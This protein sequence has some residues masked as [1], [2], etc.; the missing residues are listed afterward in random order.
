MSLDNGRVKLITQATS[1]V[2]GVTAHAYEGIVT[3]VA[4]TTAAAA[5]ET[6]TI[7]NKKVKRITQIQVALQYAG[8]GAPIVRVQAQARGSFSVTITNV[9]PSVALN[10]LAKVHF[11]IIHN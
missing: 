1:S 11:N 5:S 9:H 10:A 3:T 2:T 8:A 6:F 7:T 4:L